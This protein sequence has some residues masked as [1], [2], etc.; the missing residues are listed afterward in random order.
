MKIHKQSIL[1]LVLVGLVVYQ[2]AVQSRAHRE[3]Q[4]LSRQF[5]HQLDTLS[6]IATRYDRIQ[7]HYENI[8]ED[9][10]S[11]Q[12]RTKHVHQELTR[13][14]L[15]QQQN[16]QVLQAELQ[17]L[18]QLTQVDKTFLPSHSIDSLLFKP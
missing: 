17:A 15:E 1:V 18:L 2:S 9:L 10:L 7:Q 16:V 6:H 4:Q 5:K 8:H 14:S 12:Y 3:V 13:L 11:T